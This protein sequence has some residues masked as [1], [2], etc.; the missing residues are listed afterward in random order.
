[1]FF[2]N[3]LRKP[4]F[5]FRKT[6]FQ[7]PGSSVGNIKFLNYIALLTNFKLILLSEFEESLAHS[8]KFNTKFNKLINWGK[9]SS[10]IYSIHWSFIKNVMEKAAQEGI[11]NHL[12]HTI[13]QQ[14]MLKTFWCTALN[15]LLKLLSKYFYLDIK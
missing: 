5:I 4:N 10:L 12:L 6:F 8:L 1:M 9:N 3:K 7:N 14:T 2:L 15:P 13:T 11:K